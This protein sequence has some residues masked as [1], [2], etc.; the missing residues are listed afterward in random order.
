MS[1]F[2]PTIKL[3]DGRQVVLRE[4]SPQDAARLVSYMKTVCSE[5]D[6]MSHA[7]GEYN[8]SE[9]QQANALLRSSEADNQL[10]LLA[11]IDD[12]IVGDL[13]FRASQRSR[14]R[15]LGEFGM[16]VLRSEWG[17]GIGGSLLDALIGW[18][19]AGGIITKIN[20]KVRSDNAAA[21]ALY[22]RKGFVTEGT[23]SR[24]MRVECVYYDS[25]WMGL[26]L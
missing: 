3:Q 5:S 11:L 18:A 16:S 12:E 17:K 25:H 13:L 19:R 22:Q 14:L 24:D 1:E 2:H 10:Y 21:I 15:H 9:E 7:P 8:L 20:L 26:E 6:F 23:T 4:A